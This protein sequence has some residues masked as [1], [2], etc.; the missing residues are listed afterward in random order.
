MKTT[1]TLSFLSEIHTPISFT[2]LLFNTL[3]FMCD[4]KILHYHI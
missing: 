1:V 2:E 4:K 3:I